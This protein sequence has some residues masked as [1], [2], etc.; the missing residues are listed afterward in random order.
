[1]FFSPLQPINSNPPSSQSPF[2][3]VLNIHASMT[4]K[5]A[6]TSCPTTTS[7]S[8]RHYN[9]R[10][11]V[12]PRQP[13]SRLLKQTTRRRSAKKNRPEEDGGR[14][15][16]LVSPFGRPIALGF[17]SVSERDQSGAR[18]YT[19]LGGGGGAG[20]RR[21]QAVQQVSLTSNIN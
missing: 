3:S 9:L 5:H 7:N 21:Q 18:R 11:L 20:A 2:F 16:C 10:C 14:P 19:R 15:R 13:P 17:N 4:T 1:M 12:S 6:T 8:H